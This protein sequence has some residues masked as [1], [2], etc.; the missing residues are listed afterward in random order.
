MSTATPQAP[1]LKRHREE[2]L[3][4]VAHFL[5]DA[6]YIKGW[7][8]DGMWSGTAWDILDRHAQALANTEAEI[9][10]RYAGLMERSA[11]ALDYMLKSWRVYNV[12]DAVAEAYGQLLGELRAELKGPKGG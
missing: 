8:Q 3:R 9:H 6:D 5:G 2:A 10:A 12:D 7:V 11:E 4:A 1:V